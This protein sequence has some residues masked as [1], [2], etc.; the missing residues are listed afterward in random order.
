MKKLVIIDA[1][2]L[3]HRAFH[4]LPALS[5]AKGKVVNAVYGFSAVLLK[6]IKELDPDYI[7]ACYDLEG[8]TFRHEAFQEYKV[9][10]A[11]APQELYDQI[12]L[13]KDVLNAFGIQILEKEGYEADDL[14]GAAAQKMKGEKDLKVIIVTGDLD[15]LQLVD[16]DKVVVWTMKKG[17]QDTVLYSEKEVLKRYDLK[18]EQL[19]DFKGLKGDPS[20]N[21]PGVPGVGDKT[22]SELIKKYGSIENLYKEIKKPIRQAQGKGKFKPKLL[23]NLLKNED[24]AYFS[25][26]LATIITDLELDIDLNSLD[27]KKKFNLQVLEKLF[28]EFN[29]SSLLARI[30]EIKEVQPSLLAEP[31][32]PDF[33]TVEIETEKE[34]AELKS[35]LA[36]SDKFA[37]EINNNRF[38]FSFAPDTAFIISNLEKIILLKDVFENPEIKKIGHNLKDIA[39]ELKKVGIHIQGIELDTQIAVWLLNSSVKEAGFEELYFNEFQNSLP[40]LSLSNGPVKCWAPYI[41]KTADMLWDKLKQ[42]KLLN[43]LEDIE[44]PLI[45]VLAEMELNGVKIDKEPLK[46]LLKKVNEEIGELE[47]K[48]YKMAGMEFN[49]NSPQ[50]LGEVLFNRLNI[51][52]RVRRT[53]GGALSTAASELDKLYDKH[54]IIEL[55]LKNRELQKLKNTYIDPFPSLIAEDGR[56][57]T[58]YIQT[59]TVTG[60]LS[61]QNPNLQNIPIRT[62]LGLQFRRAFTAEEGFKIVSLDYSQIELRIAAH[63]SRDKKMSEAFKKGEDIHL[64]T[65]AEMFDVRPDEVTPNM[66]RQAKV[67]NF[68]VLYGM[69][70]L[71]FS[72]SAGVS[73]DQAREFIQRYY[74]EFSGIAEYVERVKQEAFENGFVQNMFGRKRH[75]PDIYSTIPEVKRQAERMAINMPIQSVNA[76]IMKIA[77]IRIYKYI[78]ENNLEGDA[79]MIMQVHDELVFEIRE[80][81]AEELAK[82]FKKI[83]AGVYKFDVPIVVDAKIG[84][85]WNELELLTK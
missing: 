83:M 4:A 12:P 73:R 27:W 41:L 34:F 22:A 11:R 59:G 1:H 55:I 19:P 47:S 36:K 23:E 78:H 57:H 85:N 46:A 84:D 25:K 54:P 24:Q 10:R 66:R 26:Q 37:V 18:P 50:Q 67:L 81:K 7:V 48:I 43:L 13:T 63:I 44:L 72:R 51:K 6:M 74:S 77:M 45:S 62:P 2:A 39:K 20:D 38:C 76:D 65:A 28:K 49:I 69:G 14:I 70:E 82:E 17:V 16:D 58:S 79:K 68:G 29:F 80:H 64:R 33:E 75:L 42:E 61:S 52:G 32:K 71:A 60:R 5:S 15:T 30:P 9:H 31:A 21:I 35:Q 8:P 56:L 53:G 40:A 3:I